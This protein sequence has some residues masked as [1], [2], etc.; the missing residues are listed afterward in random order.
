MDKRPSFRARS[1]LYLN[2]VPWKLAPVE[3]L[4]LGRGDCCQPSPSGD[5]RSGLGGP[6]T[7]RGLPASN[8]RRLSCK[9]G[10]LPLEIF[11]GGKMARPLWQ[12]LIDFRDSQKAQALSC[13]EC[14]T[15]LEFYA[16][17]L[18]SGVDPHALQPAIKR[19]LTHCPDCPA[20]F[21][22]WLSRLERLH[23]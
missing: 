16:D 10:K 4:K 22:D 13:D 19:N 14:F 21:A 5:P 17:Q 23:P 20:K 11:P 6:V 7:N 15:I 18:A 3:K 8:Q 12:L 1:P 2:L 9:N